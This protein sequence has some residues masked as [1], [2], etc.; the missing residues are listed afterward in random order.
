[1]PLQDDRDDLLG[2]A[3]TGAALGLWSRESLR[4][5]LRPADLAQQPTRHPCSQMGWLHGW[6]QTR[7]DLGTRRSRCSPGSRGTGGRSQR[8]HVVG[9][10]AHRTPAAPAAGPPCPLECRSPSPGGCLGQMQG[11]GVRSKERADDSCLGLTPCRPQGPPVLP[12]RLVGAS[13]PNV[14]SRQFL[15][16]VYR[17][18]PSAPSPLVL[19][20]PRPAFMSKCTNPG[21]PVLSLQPLFLLA[22][23]LT[24]QLLPPMQPLPS[25]P[26]SFS[27][28]RAAQG[29]LA[30]RKRCPLQVLSNT[31]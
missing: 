20:V 6:T 1:M 28:Q 10:A 30:E 22:Y 29:L 5:S 2:G 19:R 12:D 11:K 24:S 9:R 26:P 27:S 23:L 16:Q 31:R 3:S 14:T 7:R 18:M 4:L 15:F 21:L 17:L 25:P 8:G 13:F